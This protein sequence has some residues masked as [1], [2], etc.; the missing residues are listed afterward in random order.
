MI[1]FEGIHFGHVEEL[2]CTLEVLSLEAMPITD[3][4]NILEET[5]LEA[6]LNSLSLGLNAMLLLKGYPTLLQKVVEC[7]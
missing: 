4:G 2:C 7:F 1:K 5:H 3:Q 6:T